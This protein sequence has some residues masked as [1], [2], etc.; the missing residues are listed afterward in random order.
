MRDTLAQS[1]DAFAGSWE[2]LEARLPNGQPGY[3]GTIKI[4]PNRHVFD[5][6]WAITAGHY[7]G[8]GLATETHLLVSCGEQR[9]GLGLALYRA[10]A[11]GKISVL[12]STPE[13]QGAWGV[14]A[15]TSAYKGSFVGE[16][17]LIQSLPDGSLHGEWTLNIQKTGEVFAIVWRKGEMVHFNGLGL[18]I[19]G[20]IAVG[21]YP[22]PLQL[23]LLDYT[24]EPAG[25]DRLSAAWVLGGFTSLGTEVLIRK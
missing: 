19:E 13:L 9:A 7:A 16:H 20:G 21:W 22:D 2:V 6:T 3:T 18:E 8:I 10:Q 23:A 24:V 5:L 25:S 15:F 11:D 1:T 12:W 17:Q 4:Q 14:G